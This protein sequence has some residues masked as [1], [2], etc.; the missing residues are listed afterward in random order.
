M[1]RIFFSSKFE[2][3]ESAIETIRERFQRDLQNPAPFVAYDKVQHVFSTECNALDDKIPLLFFKCMKDCIDEHQEL[4]VFEGPSI[5]PQRGTVIGN[6]LH[7]TPCKDIETEDQG[8]ALLD[9]RE[10][11][12]MAS[13]DPSVNGDQAYYWP[14]F[15]GSATINWI[16]RAITSEVSKLT[17]CIITEEA[18]H[19]HWRIDGA[20]NR[21]AM[22]KLDNLKSVVERYNKPSTANILITGHVVGERRIEWLNLI[23]NEN[24]SH[25]V[26]L[27]VEVNLGGM[28]PI[29]FR[30]CLL[31]P[32]SNQIK[33]PENLLV[34]GSSGDW[35]PTILWN[36]F[37]Y[38][39]FGS[40]YR[41][42]P[43]P[44][45]ESAE[46]SKGKQATADKEAF[47]LS[48]TQTKNIPRINDPAFHEI[49][50]WAKK[51][52]KGTAHAHGHGTK[53]FFPTRNPEIDTPALNANAIGLEPKATFNEVAA[54]PEAYSFDDLLSG[55]VGHIGGLQLPSHT[56]DELANKAEQLKTTENLDH[57]TTRR[58]IG[59][60]DELWGQD[61]NQK[62]KVPKLSL[63]PSTFNPRAYGKSL[64][65]Q[66]LR[67]Q[68]FKSQTLTKRNEQRLPT[69][70][71]GSGTTRFQ[72]RQG[73]SIVN[74]KPGPGKTY[75]QAISGPTRTQQHLLSEQ[76][77]KLVDTPPE[78]PQIRG[79]WECS[80]T[81]INIMAT[82]VA[83]EAFP[84]LGVMPKG[85]QNS[86]VKRGNSSQDG[87]SYSQ[88]SDSAQFW[89]STYNPAVDV[90]ALTLAQIEQMTQSTDD[91][92]PS[93]DKLQ[94]EDELQTRVF[95]NTMNQ[96]APKKVQSNEAKERQKKIEDAWGP[97]VPAK[98][99]R[100]IS[101]NSHTKPKSQIIK[102]S[103]PKSG[104]L[105][106]RTREERIA[107][108]EL[109]RKVQILQPQIHAAFSSVC[110]LKA[111]VEFGVRIGQILTLVPR[112]K[113]ASTFQTEEQWNRMF[114]SGNQ[115]KSL[116]THILTRNGADVDAILNLCHA[117]GTEILERQPVSRDVQYVFLCQTQTTEKFFVIVQAD[118][119]F[120]LKYD[121][122]KLLDVNVHFA[123]SI[124]DA[125]MHMS[126]RYPFQ[127]T[128]A[129]ME[130]A[131][132]FV[133][134]I[135]VAPDPRLT[136]VYRS[137]NDF[138]VLSVTAER[139][140]HHRCL[141]LECGDVVVC[142]RETQS[143]KVRSKGDDP[144]LWLAQGNKGHNRTQ[145][146]SLHYELSLSST[147]INE[148]L[149]SNGSEEMGE[150]NKIFNKDD[151]SFSKAVHNLLFVTDMIVKQIDEVG[152]GN[153]EGVHCVKSS[154]TRRGNESAR[155]EISV[156]PADS[157]TAIIAMARRS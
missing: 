147:T 90:S 62:D 146:V 41:D 104:G 85:L 44:G 122:Q 139:S 123:A 36:G 127:A 61:P 157:A 153:S 57:E 144:S 22:R 77:S 138:E 118:G 131:R 26:V 4:D 47:E 43:L 112:D 60:N 18:E 20:N 39:Q 113:T 23:V 81:N 10:H 55:N 129:F 119:K 120:D 106:G 117:K 56:F 68:T 133:N 135:Y 5:Q 149:R 107:Y 103:V 31:D 54:G 101:D 111:E 110:P 121:A 150:M 28:I 21:G 155:S 25:R 46:A 95:H 2:F 125:S 75:A 143:L 89:I 64:T 152:V 97:A 145:N 102:S 35:K 151:L 72:D 92:V 13:L 91:V 30:L 42:L 16:P 80:G 45:L 24:A 100:P 50:N 94:S 82:D 52:A 93:K 108:E 53:P 32:V 71:V 40:L 115:L 8:T 51:T 124:W 83:Q 38:S 126:T 7:L 130:S 58:S 137:A 84:Q 34:N 65:K 76:N 142:I 29:L 116:F 136:L 141:V 6:R 73:R 11:P 49:L 74:N 48:G 154:R 86:N 9:V 87:T 128:D 15:Q 59:V 19:N 88:M 63:E 78:Q 105:L 37:D 134:S 70:D 67:E 148:S 109:S 156:G 99:P 79:H 66:I 98:Q 27:P 17:G 140:T 96:K 14:S 33:V 69:N 12:D 3:S 132:A 114:A 1:K